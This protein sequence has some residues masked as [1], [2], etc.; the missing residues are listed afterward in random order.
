V[1]VE[2]GFGLDVIPI[3]GFRDRTGAEGGLTGDLT[4]I[5]VDE[6]VMENRLNR[7]RFTLAH[8]LSHFV[9]H[10]PQIEAL[11]LASVRDWKKS[12]QAVDRETYSWMEWQAYELAGLVLVPRAPLLREY[13]SAAARARAHNID[14]AGL[15]DHALEY[16][17]GWIGDT[18][19]VSEQV[20]SKR[21]RREGVVG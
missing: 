19:Q 7:F 9:L 18:F 20:I 12:I 13:Q 3:R 11:E 17:A 2:A 21:L 1:I 14:L 15:G 4:A 5:A 10:R 8:E 6:W 16:V